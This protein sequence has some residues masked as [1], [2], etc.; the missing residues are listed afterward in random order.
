MIVVFIILILFIFT[1][2]IQQC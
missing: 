2:K 1:N